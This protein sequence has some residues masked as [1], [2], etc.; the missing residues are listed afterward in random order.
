MNGILIFRSRWCVVQEGCYCGFSRK[1]VY[2]Q[3][4]HRYSIVGRFDVRHFCRE[5]LYRKMATWINA[6]VKGLF[7]LRLALFLRWRFV[8]MRKVYYEKSLGLKSE[9]KRTQAQ[10]RVVVSNQLN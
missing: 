8:T 6:K 7:P 2:C 5:I 4:E 10:Q 9:G 3:E 1:W